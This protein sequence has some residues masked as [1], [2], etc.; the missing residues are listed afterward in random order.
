MDKNGYQATILYVVCHMGLIF[1]SIPPICF[2][3]WTWGTGLESPSAMRCM[4]LPF[5]CT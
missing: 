3:A 2:P 4:Q 5:I 1:F